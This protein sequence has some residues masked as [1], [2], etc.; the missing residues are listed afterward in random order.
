MCTGFEIAMI[1]AA[2]VGTGT[3]VYSATQ[4]PDFG[5]LEQPQLPEQPKSEVQQVSKEADKQTANAIRSARMRKGIPQPNTLL[6]G[7]SGIAD[8]TLNLGGSRLV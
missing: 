7:P 1:S 5:S 2:V 3:A 4:T 8:E 6:T